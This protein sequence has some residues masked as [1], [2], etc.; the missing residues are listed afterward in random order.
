MQTRLLYFFIELALYWE[1]EAKKE[2]QIAANIT[3]EMNDL[4]NFSVT[5]LEHINK[6][7][8]H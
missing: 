5:Y 3:E 8:I 2:K 6:G 1:E 4:D 7:K